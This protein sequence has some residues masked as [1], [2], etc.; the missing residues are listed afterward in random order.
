[1]KILRYPKLARGRCIEQVD[2]LINTA[3]RY[4]SQISRW[5]D[6]QQANS[7]HAQT[8]AV[9]RIYPILAATTAA[10][11]EN[12]NYPKEKPNCVGMASEKLKDDGPFDF[13]LV[14]R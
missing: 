14:D 12:G 6:E 11:S 9:Q 3:G 10:G 1:M 4:E 8:A 7:R 2:A 5:C 13:D